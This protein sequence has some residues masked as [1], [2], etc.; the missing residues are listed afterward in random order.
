MSN[1][2]LKNIRS[3]VFWSSDWKED[4]SQFMEALQFSSAP[5]G[6]E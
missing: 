1:E 4:I 3:Y 5:W 6:E 2:E